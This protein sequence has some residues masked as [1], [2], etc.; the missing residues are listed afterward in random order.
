MFLVSDVNKDAY[1]F[2][3]QM[4]TVEGIELSLFLLFTIFEKLLDSHGH[5]RWSPNKYEPFVYV[6][7]SHT[8]LDIIDVV[9]QKRILK[10]SLKLPAGEKFYHDEEDYG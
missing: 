7:H 9:K 5:C 1:L 3:L 2:H 8:Y 10:N 6:K 4:D